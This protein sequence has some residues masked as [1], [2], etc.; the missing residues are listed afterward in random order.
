M[1]NATYPEAPPVTPHATPCPDVPPSEVMLLKYAPAS[2]G[3]T[4]FPTTNAGL[5]PHTSEAR[6]L[7][8]IV[9][10]CTIGRAPSIH[11]SMG[12]RDAGNTETVATP[13]PGGTL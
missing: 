4:S 11:R 1:A 3:P 13:R 12:L 8:P 7:W 5:T 2:I 6:V 10:T 9:G